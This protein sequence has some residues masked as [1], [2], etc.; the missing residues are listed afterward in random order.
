MP[1]FLSEVKRVLKPSGYFLFADLRG[2][3]EV[4]DLRNDIA[5]SGMAVTG[6]W[7]IT[8]NVLEALTR[9]NDRKLRL[10]DQTV[11]GPLVKYFKDFAGIKDAGVY[12]R[13]Q[14]GENSYLRYVLKKP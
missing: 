3:G 14:K 10:I 2:R 11:R 5:N 4:A 6:H 13:F 1:R 8:A 7:D 9:D 12:E